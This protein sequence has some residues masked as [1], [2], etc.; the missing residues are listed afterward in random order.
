LYALERLAAIADSVWSAEARAA[1]FNAAERLRRRGKRR[2]GVAALPNH[3][4]D[5]SGRKA[6]GALIRGV[7]RRE[8]GAGPQEAQLDALHDGELDLVA[9]RLTRDSPW[10]RAGESP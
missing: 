7:A 8:G 2:L 6:G 5:G 10:N 3:V 9:D 4:G 1:A